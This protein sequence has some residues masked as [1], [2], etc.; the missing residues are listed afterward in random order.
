VAGRALQVRRRVIVEDVQA[1][2]AY[3]GNLKLAKLEGYS[4]VQSVPI[5]ARDG[6][7]KGMLSTHF[8]QAH[9]PPDTVLQLTDLYVR[10]AAEPL[11]RAQN[12]QS[13]RAA[14]DEADRANQ[15]KS[16]FLATASHDFRQPVQALSFLNG[17]LRRMPLPEDAVEAVAQQE[18]SI[19][20]MARLLDALLDISKLESGAIKPQIQ[21]FEV[22][23]ALEELRT[24]F[25][26]LARD[27]GLRLEIVNSARSINSD[28]MLVGQILRN[29]VSNA[30]RYTREGSVYLRCRE[31]GPSVRIEVQDTGIGIALE[32]LPYIFDEFYQVKGGR[33]T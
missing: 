1:D 17:S 13:L 16:R 30:I 23:A 18:R 7:I 4:A 24:E 5:I 27:K 3:A 26:S 6:N 25:A 11:E 19:L 9:L 29:L 2:T 8:R 31:D 15:A 20:G 10:L 21:D 28:P 14:R 33:G 32:H 12:E 22:A